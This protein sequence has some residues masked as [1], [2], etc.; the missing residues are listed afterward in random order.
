MGLAQMRKKLAIK[1]QVQVRGQ[2]LT[3]KKT[4]LGSSAEIRP[5]GEDRRNSFRFPVSLF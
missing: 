4:E 2:F 5:G 3:F 1:K